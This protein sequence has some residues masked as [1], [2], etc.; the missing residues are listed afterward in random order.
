MEIIFSN[1]AK[2]IIFNLIKVLDDNFLS[3]SKSIE[4]VDKLEQELIDQ[5]EL[6]SISQPPKAGAKYQSKKYGYPTHCIR[7]KANASTTWYILIRIYEQ[8]VF[9]TYIYNNSN[10][11]HSILNTPN[12]SS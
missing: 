5:I 7:Y 6:I 3:Y 9:V 4:Y 8:T 2:E 1:S 12:K 11:I 10:K